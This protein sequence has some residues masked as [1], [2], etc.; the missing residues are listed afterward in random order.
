MIA[1]LPLVKPSPPDTSTPARLSSLTLN[2]RVLGSSPSV[3]T[4]IFEISAIAR[5]GA[6]AISY[7]WGMP[8][9]IAPPPSAL[10]K[11]T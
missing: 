6:T 11:L 9:G 5:L 4:I 3:S 10:V 8:V 1:I 7:H 2:Q